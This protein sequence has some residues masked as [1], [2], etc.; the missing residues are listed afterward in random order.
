MKNLKYIF[1]ILIINSCGIVG[2]SDINKKLG[3]SYHF[4]GEGGAQSYI[5]YTSSSSGRYPS[6]E[7]IS[8]WPT[9]LSFD[10]DE[11]FIIAKQSPDEKTIKQCLMFFKDKSSESADSI[12]KTDT[13]F[14]NMFARDTCYWIINKKDKVIKGPYNFSSFQKEKSII[15]VPN[16][17]HLRK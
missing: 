1:L 10:Y 17:L 4:L 15:G 3:N 8:I 13:F 6:I 12:M 11:N 9:V 16:K 14:L 5:Y 2:I 7:E